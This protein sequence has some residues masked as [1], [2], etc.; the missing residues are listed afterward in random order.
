LSE[1][2]KRREVEDKRWITTEMCKGERKVGEA[3]DQRR[4]EG[5]SGKKVVRFDL[6][7]IWTERARL[8]T[9]G[10]RF[11][12]GAWTIRLV[13]RTMRLGDECVGVFRCLRGRWKGCVYKE[14]KG[15]CTSVETERT[16]STST[17]KG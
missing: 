12:V 5:R 2:E 1:K 14:V 15:R 11:E 9:G 4:Q 3:K 17:P 13:S 10:Y 7:L 16:R 6:N 8:V